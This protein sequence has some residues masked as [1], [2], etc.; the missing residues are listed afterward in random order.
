MHAFV[1]WISWD[2][3][4]ELFTIPWIDR[5]VG[6]YGLLFAFG[7]FCGYWI[8]TAMLMRDLKEQKEPRKTA[9]K[10]VD[11]LCWFVVVGTI[12]GARLGHV[13]FYHPGYYAQYPWEIPKVWEGGLASHGGIVGVL[14]ALIFYL[15]KAR[16][17]LPHLTYLGLADRLAVPS[18]WVACCIRIGNFFNQEIVGTPTTLPWGV[19]FGHPFDGVPGTPLHPVQLYEAGFYFLVFCGLRMLWKRKGECLREGVLTGALF[20]SIFTWRILMEF[21]KE[22]QGAVFLDGWVQMGQLLSVPLVVVGIFLLFRT[23]EVA[24]QMPSK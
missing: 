15:P 5:P 20:T 23:P 22:P 11:G 12:V 13:L 2:P 6:W 7:F 10:L 19:I 3:A 16:R 21:V 18:A 9:L 8:L 24:P 14:L 4:R 17:E 1:A